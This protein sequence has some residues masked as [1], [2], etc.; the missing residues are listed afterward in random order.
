EEKTE[1]ENLLTEVEQL[2]ESEDV[3]QEQID[4]A[5]TS[6]QEEI[7]HIQTPE[8]TVDKTVL[9]EALEE[10]R[11]TDIEN[12]TDESVANLQATITQAEDV[13]ADDKATVEAVTDATNAIYDAITNLE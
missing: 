2:L 7:K 10:A 1:I 11:N 4:V 5:T 13:L 12:K 6:L 9:E 3:T 8:V